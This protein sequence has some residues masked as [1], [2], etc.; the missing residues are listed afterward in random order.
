VVEKLVETI[1]AALILGLSTWLL[2]AVLKLKE[3][4]LVM[5]RQRIDL[6]WAEMPKHRPE[7]W[8]ESKW[9]FRK[10]HDRSNDRIA[11]VKVEV[12][13]KPPFRN[14]P[15]VEV[16]LSKVD[17]G[18]AR[19][20]VYRAEV[21]AE[22]CTAEGFDLYFKTWSQSLLFGATAIWVAV[23]EDSLVAK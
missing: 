8:D 13:F 1:V 21:R 2:N 4:M 22:R 18:D 19:E 14:P 7:M 16:A 5:R 15:Q 20:S 11:E 10:D 6:G 17:L 12:K 23:G 3:Q 9:Q